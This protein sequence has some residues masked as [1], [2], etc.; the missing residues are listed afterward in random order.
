[1]QS[2]PTALPLIIQGGLGAGVSD[3]RLARAVSAAGQLGVVSGTALDTIIIRRLQTGDPL[4]HIRRALAHFP[5]P[6]VADRILARYF[7][8]GGKPRAKPFLSKPLPSASPSRFAQE[9]LVAANFVEVFLA[10]EGHANPVGINYLE[11]IQPPTL[12]SLYGAM[13]AGVDVVL[14]GAG[15]PRAIPGILDKLALTQPVEMHLDVHGATADAPF[16]IRFDPADFWPQ[17]PATLRRPDFYAIV[18]SATLATVLARKASGRVDGF[19]VEGPTAGGHNAPPRGPLHLSPAGEPLYSARDDADLTAIAALGLPFW[20]AG[21]YATPQRLAEARA[22][23]AAG[24]QVGTAFAYCRESGLDDAIKSQVIRLSKEHSVRVFTDPVA[25]PTGFPFKIV[26]L[27][28]TRGH[29]DS[30]QSPRACDLGYLRHAY[31]TPAGEIGWRCPAEPVA[32]YTAKGGQP[33]DTVGR[34]CV[35]NGLLAAIGLP[36]SRPTGQELPL[37]TSG[38]DVAHIARFLHA[39]HPT[40]SA[41]DVIAHLLQP[42]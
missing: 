20:L 24:I 8:P 22:A 18:A 30:P 35:C 37:V 6:G 38:D 1:M 15:I 5:M 33:A 17:G 31:Q 34:M 32:D 27:P 28:G 36:Q 29:P 11:K 2:P 42:A 13:L 39:D 10:K 7:I 19:I 12:H 40:Y 14:M 9:L 23:G 4:G 3:Y 21:S 16:H 41:A 26:Q 25:S